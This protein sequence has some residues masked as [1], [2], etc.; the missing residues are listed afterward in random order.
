MPV[1]VVDDFDTPAVSN[2]TEAVSPIVNQLLQVRLQTEGRKLVT[3]I[4]CGYVGQSLVVPADAMNAI[5]R[6]NI[7]GRVAILTGRINLDGQPINSLLQAFNPITTIIDRSIIPYSRAVFDQQFVNTGN[8]SFSIPKEI[9]E[10]EDVNV[11]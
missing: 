10:G 6:T 5:S 2:M 7:V 9:P 8:F 4:Q 3:D 1:L 11:F